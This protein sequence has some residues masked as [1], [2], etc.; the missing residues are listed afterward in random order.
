MAA[1]MGYTR[2]KPDD[3]D[4][5]YS[6]AKKGADALKAVHGTSYRIGSTGRI[7]YLASGTARSTSFI[8]PLTKFVV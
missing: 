8:R 5:L 6:L 2:T 1:A 7:L 3:Y 4:D